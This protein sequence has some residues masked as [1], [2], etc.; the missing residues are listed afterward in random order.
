[1]NLDAQIKKLR[2]LADEHLRQANDSRQKAAEQ[3]ETATSC[4][5][6]A[7]LHARD[8]KDAEQLARGF[9]LIAD[10]LSSGE[11]VVDRPAPSLSEMPLAVAFGD[12]LGGGEPA[13]LA[14]YVAEQAELLTLDGADGGAL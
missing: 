9:D 11:L 14:E 8:A 4:M 7:A 12:A 5:R 10:A 3:Q 1:M 13:D 6:S 2:T